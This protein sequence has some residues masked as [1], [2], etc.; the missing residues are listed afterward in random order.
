[1]HAKFVTHCSFTNKLLRFPEFIGANIWILAL[2]WLPI[3]GIFAKWIELD[4]WNSFFELFV[5][6][7]IQ[8][9]EFKG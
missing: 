3:F 9:G 8:N 6:N 4:S 5:L 7:K 2:L 1:M